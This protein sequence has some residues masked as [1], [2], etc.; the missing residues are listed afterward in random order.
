VQ[1]RQELLHGRPA[2]Q[3]LDY[4]EQHDIDLISIGTHG[5]TGIDRFVMGSVAEKVIRRSEK[6][7]LTVRDLGEE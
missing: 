4:A 6:P 3:L 7:V 1:A 5:R 2:E